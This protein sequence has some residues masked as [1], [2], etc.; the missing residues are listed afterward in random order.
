MAYYKPQS[1]IKLGEDHIYPLTT[2]DQIILSDGTRLEKNGVVS[3]AKFYSATF[4][5]NNWTSSAPYTQTV[6]IEGMRETSHPIV[7]I[8]MSSA[9]T[10]NIDQLSEVWA[11]IGRVIT[12]DNS[13]TVYCYKNK[14]T[15][16]FTLNFI[17][18]E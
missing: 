4:S 6:A 16:N 2:A 5:V 10:D 8:D 1:P 13:A 3:A 18:I 9:T 17:V 11:N 15:I 7:D 14:P 12:N